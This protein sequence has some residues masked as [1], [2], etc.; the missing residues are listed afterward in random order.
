MYQ[1]S[2][3]QYF[4]VSFANSAALVADSAAFATAVL[5][6]MYFGYAILKKESYSVLLSPFTLACLVVSVHL[7][8]SLNPLCF[9]P[10]YLA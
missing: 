4:S 2:F 3:S 10:I 1:A 6:G 7:A 9:V 8:Y 5:G